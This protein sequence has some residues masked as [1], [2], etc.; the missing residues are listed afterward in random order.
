MT[1]TPQKNEYKINPKTVCPCNSDLAFNQCCGPFISGEEEAP[2][3]EKLMRARYCAYV[4]RNQDYL[5]R[6]W[7]PASR[8]EELDM[9]EFK[10]VKWLGLEIVAT[11][12]GGENDQH[13]TVE[14][15]ARYLLKG[16]SSKIIEK[17]L[18]E[19]Q[20]GLWFY[21]DADVQQNAPVVNQEKIGRNEPCPCGSN[22]KYKK[23][24]LGKSSR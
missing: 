7:H 18:F 23:C 6:T 24:C 16:Q 19:R 22:K 2:T 15:I 1:T 5:L 9:G 10:D 12:E 3:A 21:R 8:P 13:G 20:D 17:S 11:E 4:S 14:F